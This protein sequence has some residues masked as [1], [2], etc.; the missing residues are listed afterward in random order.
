MGVSR[1]RFL[2]GETSITDHHHRSLLDLTFI[3]QVMECKTTLIFLCVL[4]IT[5]TWGKS[6]KE[7]SEM[8]NLK[9]MKMTQNGFF[10]DTFSD[11]FGGFQTMKKRGFQDY[12]DFLQNREFGYKNNAQPFY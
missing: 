3:M 7:N 5:Q 6:L 10:G 1:C 8:R 12:L 11:G 9:R 4:L 2:P